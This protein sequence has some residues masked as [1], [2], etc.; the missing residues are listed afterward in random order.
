MVCLHVLHPRMSGVL[1][2]SLIPCITRHVCL[3]TC[4]PTWLPPGPDHPF[5]LVTLGFTSDPLEATPTL[6]PPHPPPGYPLD[7]TYLYRSTVI[8]PAVSETRWQ[9]MERSNS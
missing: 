1:I 5:L 2:A 4:L 7:L 6:T 3:L 9:V 8:N